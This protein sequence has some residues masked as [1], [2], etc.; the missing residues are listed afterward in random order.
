MV[1]CLDKHNYLFK[2]THICEA[3]IFPMYYHHSINV[4][5]MSLLMFLV[6]VVQ[7]IV[8]KR[9]RNGRN[10]YLVKWKGYPNSA[11]TWEPEGNLDCKRLVTKYEEEKMKEGAIVSAAASRMAEKKA[12]KETATQ[13]SIK[14]G[15]VLSINRIS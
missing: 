9:R 12:E 11:N 1:I 8:N 6:S 4:M 2:I 15:S 10:E 7:R 5:Y 14:V 13:S 3:Y